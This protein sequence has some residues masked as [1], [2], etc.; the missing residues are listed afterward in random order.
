[1]SLRVVPCSLADA[2][3][4]VTKLHRHHKAPLG[5]LWAIA[6]ADEDSGICG[7]AVIGRP[8]ARMLDDGLTVEVTRLCTD[9]TKNACS[10]LYSAA[11]RGAMARGYVYGITYILATETG[12]SLLASGWR[13]AADVKGAEW[14][15]PSRHRAEGG[16]IQRTDKIRFEWGERSAVGLP[17]V[18]QPDDA[19][20]VDLFDRGAA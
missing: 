8:V 17:R 11:R 1:V 14:S 13:R 2:K 7:V 9:G 20:Q 16:E 18:E 4:F 12:S 10:L 15:R 5:G 3:A 19:A 6:A